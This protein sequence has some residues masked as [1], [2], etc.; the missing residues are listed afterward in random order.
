LVRKALAVVTVSKGLQERLSA[1]LGRAVLLSYNGFF[2]D[3][4][5][6]GLAPR[7]WDDSR[8]HVVYTGRLYVGK[9]DPQPLF[10]ALRTL[11]QVMPELGNHIAIDFYGFE[12]PWL[13]GLV[14]KHG[15]EDCVS[16]HAYIP[17]HRSL[18]I[19]QA[20]DVL[21]F[22]DWAD[23]EAEGVLTGK[24]FEYLGSGRPI[25]S[26]GPRKSSEAAAIINDAG[27]G[28]SL[29]TQEEIAEFLARLIR[30]G[31]P[32]AV[33]TTSVAKFSRERQAR[34]L[35]DALLARIG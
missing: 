17:H 34:G 20:A 24:L 31:R 15:V 22:L 35:L 32:P 9:R 16:L 21:L 18:E 19:Q 25:L 13:R 27:C 26:V 8:L 4:R 28:V 5:G 6:S 10:R 14:T 11:R 7:P 23:T 2:E 3:D 1:Y 33:D 29:V 12:D 30:A